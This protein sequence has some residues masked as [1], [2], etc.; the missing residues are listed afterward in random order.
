MIVDIITFGFSPGTDNLMATFGFNAA[1][2]IPIPIAVLP[3]PFDAET[4]IAMANPQ[5]PPPYIR[6][7]DTIR[8]DGEV[9]REL[10][11][12][13][14]GGDAAVPRVRHARFV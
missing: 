11:G 13:A 8:I 12:M 6:G 9:Q 3:H 4:S 5:Q 14:P 2:P 1:P 7:P 10:D